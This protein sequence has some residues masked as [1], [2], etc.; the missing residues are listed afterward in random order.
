[1]KKKY[2][3]AWLVMMI[4][5]CLMCTALGYFAICTILVMA[6]H[7][8]QPWNIWTIICKLAEGKV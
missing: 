7:G 1:M 3:I 2:D 5:Y 8:N 6:Q 4:G